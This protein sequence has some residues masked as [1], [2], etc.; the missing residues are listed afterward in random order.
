MNISFA[1][2]WQTKP[3]ERS[4]SGKP[5]TV[6]CSKNF[7]TTGTSPRKTG[8][9]SKVHR[10]NRPLSS[11]ISRCLTYS[12]PLSYSEASC[13]EV[14]RLRLRELAQSAD[15]PQSNEHFPEGHLGRGSVQSSAGSQS[16]SS[17]DTPCNSGKICQSGRTRL[18]GIDG[19]NSRKR[20]RTQHLACAE[21]DTNTAT[22]TET[23][24]DVH[25]SEDERVLSNSSLKRRRVP[26]SGFKEEDWAL[27][28]LKVTQKLTWKDTLIKFNEQF[29]TER[30]VSALQARLKRAKDHGIG[31]SQSQQLYHKKTKNDAKDYTKAVVEKIRSGLRAVDRDRDRLEHFRGLAQ[32]EI[33][34]IKYEEY[35]LAQAEASAKDGKEMPWYYR[36]VASCSYLVRKS[37]EKE[38]SI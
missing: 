26:S 14:T 33:V 36:F 12:L 19:G 6:T 5:H 7:I 34:G 16:L 11:K 35:L 20:S 2:N 25:A 29:S 18:A 3:W 8:K 21:L 24:T 1:A 23:G 31:N 37:D 22:G 32:Q 10:I 4:G 15:R 30:N 13:L 17:T 28:N 9:R 27:Y 38:V